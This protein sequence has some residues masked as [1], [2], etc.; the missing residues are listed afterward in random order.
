MLEE[1]REAERRAAE[2]ARRKLA[3]EKRARDEAEL[4]ER[5]AAEAV[6]VCLRS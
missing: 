4:A 5:R 1:L 3:A 6:E 2:A